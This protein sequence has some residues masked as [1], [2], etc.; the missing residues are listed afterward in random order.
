[1]RVEDSRVRCRVSFF[2]LAQQ[3]ASFESK[4][5]SVETTVVSPRKSPKS[6]LSYRPRPRV[7]VAVCLCPDSG[8][9]GR[10][11]GF[12]SGSYRQCHHH[13]HKPRHPRRTNDQV[14][15]SRL[16]L[17]HFSA[18]WRLQHSSPSGGIQGRRTGRGYIKCDLNLPV[19]FHTTGRRQQRDRR[20]PW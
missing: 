17:S 18:A 7:V 16:L 5:V 1:M 10:C 2:G 15:P 3:G 19:G 14:K 20:R 9:V 11:K 13:C 8:T 6:L 12:I 4:T